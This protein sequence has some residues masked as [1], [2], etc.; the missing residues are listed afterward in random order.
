[1]ES[2]VN[3]TKICLSTINSISFNEECKHAVVSFIEN[4]CVCYIVSVRLV[5]ITFTLLV[6]LFTLIHDIYDDELQRGLSV[7]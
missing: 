2:S 5:S 6:G 1:M 7:C 3:A 4:T